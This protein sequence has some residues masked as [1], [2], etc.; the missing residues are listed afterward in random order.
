MVAAEL[1]Y[2]PPKPKRK[3][4]ARATAVVFFSFEPCDFLIFN[5]FYYFYVFF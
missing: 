3:T 4:P 1:P 2:T 5:F